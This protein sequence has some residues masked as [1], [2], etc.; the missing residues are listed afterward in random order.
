MRQSCAKDYI[1]CLI[2]SLQSPLEVLPPPSDR[3]T[4][5]L[6][7]VKQMARSHRQRS[8]KSNSSQEVVTKETSS[9]GAVTGMWER[10][11]WSGLLGIFNAETLLAQKQG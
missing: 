1:L 11:V 10:A 3:R 4:N 6:R 7:E 8:W 2:C 5:K 9:H